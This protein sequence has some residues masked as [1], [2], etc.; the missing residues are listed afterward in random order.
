MGI[1][2]IGSGQAPRSSPLGL[3]C[4]LG[5]DQVPLSE[6]RCLFLCILIYMRIANPDKGLASK[7]RILGG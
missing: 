3:A 4:E 5:S 1:V 2:P 7:S 6:C